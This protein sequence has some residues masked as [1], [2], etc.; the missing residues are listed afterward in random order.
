MSSAASLSGYVFIM[1]VCGAFVVQFLL[2]ERKPYL[3]FIPFGAT[4]VYDPQSETCYC[5]LY[6]FSN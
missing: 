6:C 3:L 1:T 4:V 2:N 5:Y